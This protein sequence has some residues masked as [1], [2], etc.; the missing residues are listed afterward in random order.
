M[1]GD[2][3]MK[4][5]FRQVTVSHLQKILIILLVIKGFWFIILNLFLP[6][7]GINYIHENA[8]KALFYKI[9][10]TT[11][12]NKIKKE[13]QEKPTVKKVFEGKVKDISLLAIYRAQNTTVITVSYKKKTKVM[14]LGDSLKGF[15][16]E[17]AQN[18][19]V[20]F[21][22]ASKS[23]KIILNKSKK[24][25][26][27]IRE[28]KRVQKK[29]KALSGEISNA[30]SYKIIDKSLITHYVENIDDIY[31]NVGITEVRKDNI[32][33]GF[34][35]SFV[36]KN[37]PFSKLGIKRGD[38]IKAINGQLMNSYGAAL[39]MY[40]NLEDIENLTLVVV[41][42]KEEMELEYE[43]N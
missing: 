22:K 43:I 30:G 23:Y 13:I 3:T 16:F 1:I 35:I 29:T 26:S 5:L 18:N 8:T 28:K 27:Y 20:I 38:M 7:T 14:S 11:N 4:K 9:K 37:S 2:G 6:L 17:S 21:T 33:Q 42:G 19:F 40:K 31:K 15:V 12:D 24:K 41:R 32:L 39:E 10:L 34:R 36:R 25:Q